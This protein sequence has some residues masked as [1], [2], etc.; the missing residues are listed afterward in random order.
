MTSLPF[1]TRELMIT[2]TFSS[3][4][5]CHS[6]RMFELALIVVKKQVF[7]KGLVI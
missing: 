7:R 1:T 6:I 4:F 2:I 3:S 5:C